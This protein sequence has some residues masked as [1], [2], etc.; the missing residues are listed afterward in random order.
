MSR[1]L[2][3]IIR[4]TENEDWLALA[5]LVTN[6]RARAELGEWECEVALKLAPVFTREAE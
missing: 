4:L 6:L 5:K 1:E 3:A 2:Q